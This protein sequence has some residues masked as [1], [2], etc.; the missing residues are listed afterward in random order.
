MLREKYNDKMA[1]MAVGEL[2]LYDELFSY[3]CP[4]FITPCPPS[5]EDPSVNVNQEAFRLQLSLFLDE[6]RR[7]QQTDPALD[8]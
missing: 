6:V 1:K 3:A 4:K 2:S 5:F 8:S 7:L